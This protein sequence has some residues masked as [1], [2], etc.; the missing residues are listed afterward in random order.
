MPEYAVQTIDLT[1]RFGD[2]VAVDR[3]NLTVEK[4][5][6]YGL[7]GPDGAGKSTVIRLLSSVLKPSSGSGRVLSFDLEKESKAV[8]N[9]I[10]Y[11]SQE[12]T[13]YG[14]LTVDEN[15]QFFA[16]LHGVRDYKKRRDELLEFTYMAPFRKRQA[17]N[18]SG[19]MKK[20]LALACTLI[21]KPD[22]VFFDEP[23]TGVDPLSRGEFWRILSELLQAGL[24]IFITTPYMDEVERCHRVGMMH[25]GVLL[26]VDTPE[27]IKK[28]MKGKIA[29]IRCRKPHAAFHSIR[30]KL[31]GLDVSMFGSEI[32]L[33]TK[34]WETDTN[35]A[36]RAIF[37][38]GCGETDLEEIAPSI[39]DVFIS[40]LK[41]GAASES[42]GENESGERV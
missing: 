2:I 27:G 28:K 19:G 23:S 3:L 4:G 26:I 40:Y 7:V 15:I 42:K 5:E 31:A 24:T 39:E 37:A 8:K 25:K 12:F 9:R 22:M 35:E 17:R 29:R 1:K 21:H 38:A 32:H 34:N 13:L 20:K 36:L 33:V 6:M 41:E 11:F 16:E 18:L 14:D 10:G 30:D